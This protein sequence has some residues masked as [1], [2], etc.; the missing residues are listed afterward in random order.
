MFKHKNKRSEERGG[1]LVSPKQRLFLKETLAMAFQ[2]PV[3]TELVI[4][5]LLNVSSRPIESDDRKLR[6]DNGHQNEIFQP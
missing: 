2:K 1:E 5:I 3:R 6:R 4:S